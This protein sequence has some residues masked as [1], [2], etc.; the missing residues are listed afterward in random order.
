MP[1]MFKRRYTN[2]VVCFF[3]IQLDVKYL[4]QFQIHGQGADEEPKNLLT[5]DKTDGTLW[6]TRKVDYEKYRILKVNSVCSSLAPIL[7]TLLNPNVFCAMRIDL[8]YPHC[9]E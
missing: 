1:D 7:A 3:Q 2:G 8:I 6:M 5:I 9:T 4:V